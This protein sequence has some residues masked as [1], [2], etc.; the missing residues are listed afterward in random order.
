MAAHPRGPG[1]HSGSVRAAAALSGPT[2]PRSG[3]NQAGAGPN[4]DLGQQLRLS[5]RSTCSPA[6][7]CASL[8]AGVFRALQQNRCPI[9]PPLHHPSGSI[10]GLKALGPGPDLPLPLPHFACPPLVLWRGLPLHTRRLMSKRVGPDRAPWR[11]PPL[12]RAHAAPNL[13][14]YPC[15]RSGGEEGWGRGGRG[16]PRDRCCLSPPHGGRPGAGTVLRAPPPGHGTQRAPHSLGGNLPN[17]PGVATRPSEPIGG[18]RP[19]TWH[20][21]QPL[22]LRIPHS[23]AADRL[24]RPG[25]ISSPPPPPGVA[26]IDCGFATRGTLLT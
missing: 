11:G 22:H 13:S 26:S 16:A 7:P 21:P 25:Q 5:S 12:L 24:P 14:P 23:L 6:H 3:A 10:V 17:S 19:P 2:P 15:P 4:P 1:N 8:H 20:G 9:V 18:A